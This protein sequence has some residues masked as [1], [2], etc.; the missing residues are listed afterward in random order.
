[1]SAGRKD[2]FPI[3]ADCSIDG[4]R[5]LY[6]EA[7]VM[8]PAAK[9]VKIRE[10]RSLRPFFTRKTQAEPREVPRKGIRMP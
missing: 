5:R 2:S 9:P 8:T 10:S 7:A 4:I 6:T 3:E 1:M